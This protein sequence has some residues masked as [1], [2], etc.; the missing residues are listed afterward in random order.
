MFKTERVAIIDL[1]GQYCHL[2]ARRLRDLDVDSEIFEPSVTAARLS[3]FSGLILSGGPQSVYEQSAVSIDPRILDLGL[4]VLGICY[5]HQLLAKLLGGEVAKQAGEYGRAPLQ[6]ETTDAVFRDTPAQQQVWMSHS[7]A[8]KV[9]PPG[10]VTTASTPRCKHAAFADAERHIFGVQFHPEVAHSEYGRTILENFVRSVCGIHTRTG[11]KDRISTL[12]ERIRNVAGSK[13]VFFLISGGVDST[14]AFV[15]CAKAL[16]KER[17]LGLYVDTGFMREGETGELRRN[18][19]SLGLGERLNIWDASN[20][21]WGA[22]KGKTDPE[23][24]RQIIGRLF[25]DIQSKAMQ[26]FGIDSEGWLLGQGTIYPDTIESGGSSGRAALIKTHHNRCEEI[27]ELLRQGRV[28]EPL[29]EFYKDE[30]RSIGLELGLS[31]HLTNRWPFPGPGLAIRCI[32]TSSLA[33]KATV[34]PHKIV[35]TLDDSGYR[36]VLIP[37]QSVGVQGDSRT[38]RKVVAIEEKNGRVDYPGLRKLSSWLCNEHTESNRVILLVAGK[39][40]VHEARV[41]PRGMDPNRVETLR[42]ADFIARSEIETAGLTD[43]I[44]QFPVVLAPI[45]FADGESIVLR[46]VNSED[47][48]TANFAEVAREILQRIGERIVK[49]PGVDAVFL[50]VTNKP[51][52]TIEWE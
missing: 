16:S 39:H 11:P 24:K 23:E 27:R 28:I 3:S 26:K 8:V 2:I 41:S 51:P 21:F 31:G 7:D 52:A 46:P 50:D 12:C 44:W 18:L 14:V 37:L 33:E 40:S 22:L 34:L 10:A 15:L 43:S 17:V 6:V 20:D 25:V 5:G 49:L 38:Y 35:T 32:C 42:R 19:D 30:V 45:S 13:S 9:L 48:M 36:G 4:P 29:A 47:G 1:G